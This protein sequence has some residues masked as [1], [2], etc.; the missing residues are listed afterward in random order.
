MGGFGAV[1][2]LPR[3][4]IHLVV[5]GGLGHDEGGVGGLCG[6]ERWFYDHKQTE[7]VS[8]CVLIDNRYSKVDCSLVEGVT[9]VMN[10]R[11]W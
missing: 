3:I 11:R 5:L 9:V 8:E 2:G 6:R 1:M 4:A 10:G 7:R